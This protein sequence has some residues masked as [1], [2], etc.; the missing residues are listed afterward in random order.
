MLDP[1]P[2]LRKPCEDSRPAWTLL[3]DSARAPTARRREPRRL[4][5]L[6]GA[7]AEG[8]GQCDQDCQCRIGSPGL[9]ILDV[10]ESEIGRFGEFFLGELKLRSMPPDRGP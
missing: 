5:Q 6:F 9:N 2:G 8:V 3:G 10:P 1:A 4:Q 7:N